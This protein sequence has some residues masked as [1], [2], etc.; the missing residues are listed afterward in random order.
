MRCV[1]EGEVLDLDDDLVAEFPG[2]SESGRLLEKT[3]ASC[4]REPNLANQC[5]RA[6]EISLLSISAPTRV[7]TSCARERLELG[8]SKAGAL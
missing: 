6:G 8:I 4:E 3:F 2:P 1:D 5:P 7:T